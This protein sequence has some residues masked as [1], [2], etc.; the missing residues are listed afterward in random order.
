MLCT[1]FYFCYLLTLFMCRNCI[2]CV[3]LSKL[4]VIVILIQN[5]WKVGLDTD[6]KIKTSINVAQL[7]IT[8][9][10]VF[11]KFLTSFPKVMRKVLDGLF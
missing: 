5:I 7:E 3:L 11:R 2:F 8:W 1:M 6:F 10:K 4:G 9:L